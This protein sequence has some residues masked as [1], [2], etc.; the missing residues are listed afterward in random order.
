L[1]DAILPFV[2]RVLGAGAAL[3]LQ[4]LLARLMTADAYG[5]YVIAWS[6]ILAL[7]S[8]VS[9]GLSDA[10]I[11]FMPRYQMRG[12]HAQTAAFFGRGFR[13]VT[14][15]GLSAACIGVI[16][17]YAL[18]VAG[19]SLPMLIVIAAGLPFIAMEYFLEG[20]ARSLGWFRFTVTLIYIIRPGMIAGTCIILHLLGIPLTLPIAGIVT[21][22]SVAA[23]AL[24][25]YLVISARLP[26][27]VSGR[28]HQTRLSRLW[29]KVAF[30]MLIV[31]SLEDIFPALD[32]MLVG[33]LLGAEDAAVYFA[34]SRILALAHFAQYAVVLVCGRS[35]SL[36]LAEASEDRVTKCLQS[37]TATT[38]IATTVALAATL[39][40]GEMLLDWFGA[41]F[42]SGFTAMCIL[43]AGLLFRSVAVPCHE[44]LLVAGHHKPLI[45][46]N[47]FALLVLAGL[48][49]VLAPAFGMNGAAAAAALSMLA[50]STLLVWQTSSA[51]GHRVFAPTHRATG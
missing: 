13:L 28:P 15:V 47:G 50:R 6:W 44:Y 39:I 45:A 1:R 19:P 14:T 32:V 27:R 42:V 40:A 29:L 20:V 46:I 5:A 35:L 22:L 10:A 48:S 16:L 26:S 37:A 23:T 11:R 24:A 3:G 9:L 2:I 33:A 12:R 17:L 31:S 21:I 38:V 8:L 36:A 30:P 4:I 25:A 51:H 7:G 34:A 49:L 43:A 18:P 41:D